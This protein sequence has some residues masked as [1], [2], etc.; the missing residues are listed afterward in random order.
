MDVS[1]WSDLAHVLLWLVGFDDDAREKTAD[2]SSA[3]IE[4]DEQTGRV[5]RPGGELTLYS[6]F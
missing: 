1:L 2:S 4:D 5:K 6:H 3:W